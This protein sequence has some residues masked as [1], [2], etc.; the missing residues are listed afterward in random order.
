M[1]P[2]SQTPPRR[3]SAAYRSFKALMLAQRPIC[4]HCCTTPS[5]IIAH[6]VQ[7]LAGGQL[8]DQINVMALCVQCDATF[9]RAN[10]PLR[11]RKIRSLNPCRN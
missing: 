11:R 2:L 8:M 1:R 5:A 10:P 7:P 6:R 3:D 9:T 4:E